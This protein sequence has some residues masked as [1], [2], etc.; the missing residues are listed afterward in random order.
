MLKHDRG[1]LVYRIIGVH[2]D[3][4]RCE[5]ASASKAGEALLRFRAA[6]NRF[7]HVVAISPDGE[8]IDGFELSRRF[9]MEEAE[10]LLD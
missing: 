3:Q 1:G 8:E 10:R 4:T 2:S 6:Q 9:Q 5:A 7:H